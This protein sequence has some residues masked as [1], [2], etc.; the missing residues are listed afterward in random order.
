[1]KFFWRVVIAAWIKAPIKTRVSWNLDDQQS[2]DL[3]LKSG[4]GKRFL[5]KLRESAADVSFRSV[6][7]DTEKAVS[8]AGY[9][10]GYCDCLGAVFRLAKSFPAE[11]SEYEVAEDQPLP[12]QP[13]QQ[14]AGQG[15]RGVI[16]GGGLIAPHS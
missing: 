10:R 8:N 5:L 13:V 15:W 4:C 9:A 3:F 12:G 11:E 16:G 6:Y 2:L 1:M 14:K 7:G